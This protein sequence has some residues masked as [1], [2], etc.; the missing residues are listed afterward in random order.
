MGALAMAIMATKVLAVEPTPIWWFILASS[1]WVVYTLDHL[2]DGWKSKGRAS[3]ERHN[4]HY[5]HRK[6]ILIVAI[7]MGLFDLILGILYFEKAV[8]MVA[9]TIILTTILYFTIIHFYHKKLQFLIQK[10]MLIA[11]IY[12]M[13]IW[14][15][16]I[17]WSAESISTPAI[18]LLTASFL[19]AWSEGILASWF[20][21]ELDTKDG[22][23]S[24][25]VLFG[26]KFTT[27]FL[28]IVFSL[29]VLLSL[30]VLYCS[31]NMVLL[32]S[33]II[34]LVMNHLLQSCSMYP[35]YFSKNERYKLLGEAVFWLPALLLLI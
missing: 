25:S 34:I 17:I 10:E 31:S 3:I 6:K 16:P 14:F 21:L 4:F 24:F 28:A 22:H 35:T 5:L 13:G 8:L 27:Y 2:L 26:L 33:A 18:A 30:F 29:I 1:V 23:C 20:E 7:P 12:T 11:I 9:F 32:S 19:L 15:A